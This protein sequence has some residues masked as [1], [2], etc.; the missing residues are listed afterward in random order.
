M[1]QIND[2]YFILYAAISR[3]AIIGAGFG[4][5]VMGYKLFVLGVMPQNGSDI[6]VKYREVRLTIKNASPG[7]IL[8]LVGLAMIVAMQIQGNPAR[9]ITR[10]YEKNAPM[11]NEETG[12]K[13]D[14]KQDNSDKETRVVYI[15][16]ESIR[17]DSE[18]VFT[19]IE[20]GKQFEQVGQ[21]DKAIASY[22]KPLKNEKLSLK[23][24]TPPLR[25][26]AA[27]YLKQERYDEAIAYASLAHNAD[28]NNAEGLALMA[29]IELQRKKY[30]R[31]VEAISRAA[32]IDPDFISERDEIKKKISSLMD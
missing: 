32:E 5:I 7:T 4:C 19:A 25:A 17:G 31:A 11:K 27:V 2:V 26:L 21:T 23:D 13:N 12:Q 3:L 20:S 30:E 18:D 10:H 16:K 8:A 6:D 24:A 14:G 28:Q 1:Q 15:E 22:T 29:V 9:E